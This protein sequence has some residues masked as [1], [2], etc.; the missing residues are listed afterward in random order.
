[1]HFNGIKAALLLTFYLV[2]SCGPSFSDQFPEISESSSSP[3]GAPETLPE[4]FLP[5][6]KTEDKTSN[7]TESSQSKTPENSNAIANNS[8]LAPPPQQPVL[9]APPQPYKEKDYYFSNIAPLNI[10]YPQAHRRSPSD[11]P[12]QPVNVVP[13]PVPPEVNKLDPNYTPSPEELAKQAKP[14]NIP[15]DQPIINE[16]LAKTAKEQKADTSTQNNVTTTENNATAQSNAMMTPNFQNPAA[17]SM[18]MNNPNYS[19]NSMVMNDYVNNQNLGEGIAPD[20]RFPDLSHTGH[21]RTNPAYNTQNKFGSQILFPGGPPLPPHPSFS[22]PAIPGVD[23]LAPMPHHQISQQKFSQ[24]VL[25]R[26]DPSL[27]RKPYIPPGPLKAKNRV[28]STA[29]FITISDNELKDCAANEE[30]IEAILDEVRRENKNVIKNLPECFRKD[31]RLILKAV[32]IDPM[33][34]EFATDPLKKDENFLRKL[35]KANP[36][37][38]QFAD[39]SVLSDKIFMERAAYLHRDVLKYGAASLTDNKP[40][41]KKMIDFDSRNYIFAS[42]R[43][44]S[45]PEIAAMALKDDGSLI[46]NAPYS[47]KSN[48]KLARIAINSDRKSF[49]FLS[50]SL[51]KD[52]KLWSMSQK[53]P[54]LSNMPSRTEM[55]EFLYKN[56][57]QQRSQKNVGQEITNKAKFAKDAFLI[58]RQYITKWQGGFWNTVSN[59]HDLHLVTAKHRN[60]KSSWKEDLAAYPELIKKVEKFFKKR[61]VNDGVIESLRLVDLV[62]VKNKPETI[63]FS[64]YLLR[65]SINA[66]LGADFSAVTSLVAISQKRNGKWNLSVAEV[67]FDSEVQ[68]SPAYKNGHKRYILWDLFYAN[69][70]DK[71]PKIIF[72]IEDRNREIFEIYGEVQGGKYRKIYTIEMNL[73]DWE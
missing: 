20:P 17:N 42:R 1:M 39:L 58:N 26:S 40:F 2:A 64:L 21:E 34:F 69:K 23:P 12:A 4:L 15:T 73:E 71:N 55:K 14:T 29:R 53:D 60:Y 46:E 5:T 3:S 19:P 54:Y 16:G 70:N 9:T 45:M 59:Q 13:I 24:E 31:R 33:Q 43:I 8:N 56:Y 44:Q 68:V 61:S 18:D 36:A 11:I 57:T 41:M 63:A 51:Q 67:I 47:I 27:F 30:L 49:K 7:S 52:D 38:L 48:S 50:K 10:L 6:E 66:K 28:P 35:I 22:S 72:K 32:M 25:S 37:I 65:D 62:L